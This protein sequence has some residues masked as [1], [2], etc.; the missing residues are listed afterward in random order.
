MAAIVKAT[1]CFVG[2]YVDLRAVVKSEG[3]L[4]FA[5]TPPDWQWSLATHTPTQS[6]ESA[7]GQ[8]EPRVRGTR[9][10]EGDAQQTVRSSYSELF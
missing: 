5:R 6:S 8:E 1:G 2:F 4:A 10:R 7:V 9:R 3:E